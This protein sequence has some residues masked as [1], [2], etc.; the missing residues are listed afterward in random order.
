MR[1][2]AVS[3]ALCSR[4][5]TCSRLSTTCRSAPT[6]AAYASIR[7]RVIWTNGRAPIDIV[8]TALLPCCRHALRVGAHD[9]PVLACV[10]IEQSTDDACRARALVATFA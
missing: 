2:T 9:Q 1:G 8:M 7:G 10:L 6:L 4:S 3:R 5:A